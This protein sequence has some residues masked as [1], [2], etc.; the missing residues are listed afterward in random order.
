MSERYK[1]EDSN[2]LDGFINWC[3]DKLTNEKS[4]KWV[5]RDQRET[6]DEIIPDLIKKFDDMQIQHT[7][8]ATLPSPSESGELWNEF[9]DL[10]TEGKQDSW[11]CWRKD[12]VNLTD[13]DG[14]PVG[15]GGDQLISSRLLSSSSLIQHHYR[16][17]N[18][19]VPI[20]LDVNAVEQGTQKMYIGN[21]TAAELDA[22][23]MVP[24]I[25][26][27]M[28]SADFGR[29]L[30]EGLMSNKEWQRVVNQKRVLAIRDF[31]NG[32]DSYIFNPVLLYLDLTNEH[33]SEVTPLNGKGQIKIDFSF[34]SKRSDGW[35]DYVP[36]PKN[37]DTRPLW[38]IDGQHRVRGF[39][40]SERG[41]HM[42]IPYVLIVSREGDDPKATERLVAKVFTEINTM[43]V[44]IDDLHQ[45]YLRY[46]FGMKG[47]SRITDYSCDEYD[48]PTQDSRPQRRAYELALYMA[49]QRDSALYNMIEFQRPANRSRRAHH[50]VVNS[51]NWIASTS[52]YYRNNGI[53]SEVSSDDFAQEEIYNFFK[54]FEKVCDMNDW[55][56]NL[57][58]WQ[59]GA[60]KNKPFLQFDGP[61]LVLLNLFPQVVRMITESEKVERPISVDRFQTLLSPLKTVDWRSPSLHDSSLKG[62]NNT[63]IRH[64][65]L[66]IA[67]SLR[68]GYC[69]SV[70]DVM[71]K[72]KR[73]IIGEGLISAPEPP[74]PENVSDDSWPGMAD[75]V[76]E[77]VLPTNALDISWT[78]KFYTPERADIWTIPKD[79]LSKRQEGTI[80]GLT[81][82][83]GD[84]P[85]SCNKISIEATSING[86][87]PGVMTSP[88]E[89]TDS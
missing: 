60:N 86:I 4:T 5:D 41:A 89:F 48:N 29:K 9:I 38:I 74:A 85:E 84:L 39:G 1:I 36:K 61:F 11:H 45:I 16:D 76:I 40:A 43:S 53:Y 62:R 6:A 58:R 37:T 68:A 42:P 18:A 27:A 49:S 35:T 57:P 65:E 73:S 2:D 78:V 10:Q 88:L 79:S 25:D 87:G 44:P 71:S 52:K 51:K 34:L 22:I 75:L 23:S 64:L 69:G 14:K 17:P 82:T 63:N 59:V 30:L 7:A 56:D 12:N 70:E 81:I 26:P 20:T 24:W 83:L 28:E 8:A 54:A 21:A 72:Q 66:W 33:V 46:K 19:L 13:S 32:E 47:D 50:Y 67:N 80:R 55:I 31:A 3:L 15:Y 77:A